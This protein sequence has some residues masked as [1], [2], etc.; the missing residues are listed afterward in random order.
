MDN[1]LAQPEEPVSTIEVSTLGY[2]KQTVDQWLDR[3][4]YE[5]INI[6]VPSTFALRFLVYMQNVNKNDDELNR[7]PPVHIKMLDKIASGSRSIVNLCFRGAAKTT[8]FFEYF[9]PFLA[10]EQELPG[11][12]N[13]RGMLYISDSIDNGVKNARKNL[14][15]R[16]STSTYL[17]EWLPKAHF[18]DQW[19]EFTRKDGAKFGIKLYGAK[20][21]IR[22]SRIYGQRPKVVVLDDLMSDD[23][24]KSKANMQ[25]IKE[26]VHSGIEYALHPTERLKI[27][28]GTPFNSEDIMIEAVES[29]AWDVNVWPVCEKFPCTREEFRGAWEDRF[30]YDAVLEMYEA[31]KL[32]GKLASFNQEMMLRISSE[33]SRLVQDSELQWYNRQQLLNVKGNFNFYI[34]TDF[35]TSSKQTADYSVISVWALNGNGDWYWVDGIV[36]R[37]TMDMTLDDLFRLCRQYMPQSVGIEVTGQ[38]GAFIQWIQQEQH[39]RNHYFNLASNGNSNQPGIR[40][41]LDKLAR[42][43]LVVPLFRAHKIYWPREMQDSPEIGKFHAQI[44]LA[45]QDGL[46]GKDDCL[47]TVSMLAFMNAVPPA[48]MQSVNSNMETRQSIAHGGS[49][50]HTQT[51]DAGSCLDS[52][53]V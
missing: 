21:G 33:E 12:K 52:Y 26:T 34:T 30:T 39:R 28:N 36:A 50:W 49:I 45:T 9:A 41:V 53:V 47:D 13:I 48:N 15:H 19:I 1:V 11:M 17:Q 3:V 43:N 35:A 29:G 5:S 20:T 37:Q 42:F 10:I 6:F 22:G 8:L 4:D 51:Y 44:R 32:N 14:E 18:T 2:Q 40:P 46:K 16:Y 27:F 38:Q 24:A 23:D 31:A 25:M 7:T